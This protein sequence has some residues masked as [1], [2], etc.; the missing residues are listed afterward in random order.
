[1]PYTPILLHPFS[2]FVKGSMDSVFDTNWCELRA[3]LMAGVLLW[4][5]YQLLFLAAKLFLPKSHGTYL[6]SVIVGQ[7]W[8]LLAYVW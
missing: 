5:R 1:M 6:Y 7:L 2:K 3:T 4:R 8:T